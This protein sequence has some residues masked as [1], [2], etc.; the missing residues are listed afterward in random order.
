MQKI[1]IAAAFAAL[2]PASAMASSLASTANVKQAPKFEIGIGESILGHTIE[3]GYRFNDNL[4]V[5]GMYGTAS[6]DFEGDVDDYNFDGSFDMS[7]A[8]V[9][10]DLYPTGG[11]FRVSLGALQMN[12]AFEGSTH[13]TVN[14]GASTYT[15]VLTADMK[16]KNDIAPAASIGF[17]KALFKSPIKLSADLGAAY[18]GGMEFTAKSPDPLVPQS[19][20]DAEFSEVNDTLNDLKVA[21]FIKVGLS[22]AF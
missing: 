15:G 18:T 3:G 13:G 11:A 2:A 7:G 14:Y 19:A 17:S 8:G 20:I 12:H 5:R 16:F 10:V 4:G 9:F 22:Y 1:L 21:P 6:I